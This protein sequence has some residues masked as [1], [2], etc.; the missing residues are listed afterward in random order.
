MCQAFAFI[1]PLVLVS[2]LLIGNHVRETEGVGGFRKAVLTAVHLAAV[3]APIPLL[4]P[5]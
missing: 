2:I 1:S 3:P 4:Q 5:V